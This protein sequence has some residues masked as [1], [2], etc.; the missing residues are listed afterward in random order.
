MKKLRLIL[1]MC[2]ILVI[3]PF[4][5][6]QASSYL[7]IKMNGSVVKYD[8][9]QA[10]VAFDGKSIDVSKTPG[11]IVNGIALFPYDVVF[12]KGLSAKCQYNHVTK[13]LSLKKD[14]N[15]VKLTAGSS[16]AYV[17]GTRKTLSVSPRE[18]YFYKSKTTKLMVPSRFV[19]EALGYTYNW[20]SNKS[21]AE[22]RTPYSLYYDKK[23]HTYTG[24]R[25]S[26][27]ING[28]TVNVS[29]M[30]TIVMSNNAFVQAQKVF[31]H[32][33]LDSQ[34]Q[35]NSK[36]RL[37]IIRNDEAEVKFTLDSTIAYVNGKKCTLK[38]APKIIKDNVSKKSAIM[39]PAKFTAESL[40]YEYVWNS[41]Q[42]ISEITVIRKKEWSLSLAKTNHSSV[43]T[44]TLQ[45]IAL[46]NEN[47]VESIRF[48]G[49]NA[50]SIEAAFSEKYNTLTLSIANLN[51][52]ETKLSKKL[53]NSNN[54]KQLKISECETGNLTI[55]M[56][57][58]EDVTYY[59]E[60]SGNSYCIYFS[61]SAVE[62]DDNT[63]LLQRPEGVSYSDITDTDCYYDKQFKITIP[64]DHVSY[65]SNISTSL[66]NGITSVKCSLNSSG[67]TVLTFHTSKV[68]GYKLFD[69]GDTF[70][71]T[72][73]NPSEIYDSIV[74]LDAGHGGVDPGCV[75][76]GLQEKNINY[77]IIYK[78]AKTYFNGKNS[79]V[80]AYWT[81]T[82]DKKIELSSRAAYSKTVEADVFISLHM[83]SAGTDAANG[84]ETF[85]SLTNNKPNSYGLTSKMVA[86]YFQN[87]W[88]S[89][90]G[91]STSRG[92]KTANYVVT[93]QN[94][95][96]AILIELGFM[97][98][99]KDINI[100]GS[101]ENQKKAAKTFYQTVCNLFEKYPTGR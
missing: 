2:L 78:Y 20:N 6:V 46:I 27:K 1:F 19:T 69:N 77:N 4:H 41:S 31:G 32:K 13:V 62:V 5:S 92:V 71:I 79:P 33:G 65:Y 98:S 21:L 83:N 25:G 56:S 96:P 60:K 61:T 44:N 85:Y 48:I 24:T 86:N 59:E 55:T 17:N 52:V 38:V 50:L 36:S 72:V 99:S 22:I 67:N 74:L 81:R 91:L 29:D 23:W 57:L 89:Q 45:S 68:L 88:S 28:T 64:G 11:I 94:T 93:K 12:G 16:I 76:N 73:G 66:P 97:T 90:L 49:K 10:K 7:K 14:G 26:V 40:G 87:N 3:T 39:V 84:T 51:N 15:T 82:T 95:V 58:L 37:I 70:G 80:K 53:T 101:S 18:V 63:I 100:I 47:G 75:S 9:T 34:Y 30:P 35:Y 54:L 8:G 42:K 43:C